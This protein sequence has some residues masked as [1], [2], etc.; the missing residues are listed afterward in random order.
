MFKKVFFFSSA[1]LLAMGLTACSDANENGDAIENT[2][3]EQTEETSKETETAQ[4]E[5]SEANDS[6]ESEETGGSA[7]NEENSEEDE[8]PDEQK[9]MA[10]RCIERNR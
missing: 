6:A 5:Q 10:I 7:V 4:P 8:I 2:L 3:E 9:Q 1:A